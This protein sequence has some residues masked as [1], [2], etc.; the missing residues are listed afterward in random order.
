MLAGDEGSSLEDTA[1]AA[2]MDSKDGDSVQEGPAAA[3][4]DLMD[5]AE[6]D[7]ATRA[8][9]Q[10]SLREMGG[11]AANQDWQDV[12]KDGASGEDAKDKKKKSRRQRAK[13]NKVGFCFVTSVLSVRHNCAAWPLP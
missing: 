5:D 11:T 7:A 10:A 13:E 12:G 3:E 9:I 4:G 8:A 2:A 6:F 1:T